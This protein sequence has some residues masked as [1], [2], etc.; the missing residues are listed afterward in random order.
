V[1]NSQ[2]KSPVPLLRLRRLV[3]SLG[4]VSDLP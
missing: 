4:S 3:L 1:F 2:E